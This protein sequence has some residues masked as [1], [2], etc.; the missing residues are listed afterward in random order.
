MVYVSLSEEVLDFDDSQ[1]TEFSL[2][3]DWGVASNEAKPN[4]W[5]FES[6][7]KN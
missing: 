4:F 6:L 1:E 3:N 5:N 2:H 7:T